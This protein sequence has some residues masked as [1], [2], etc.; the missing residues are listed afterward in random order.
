MPLAIALPKNPYNNQ[1]VLLVPEKYL[2]DLP[3]IS[4]DTF[5][6]FCYTNENET[7]RN[8][9][10]ADITRNVDKKTIINFARKHPE[11]RAEFLKHVEE[12][13]AKPYDYSADRRGLVKWYDATAQ[14]CSSVPLK[15]QFTSVKEFVTSIQRLLAEFRNYV[16]NNAGWRLLWN[17]NGQ[18]KSEEA[19]QL[20][21]LGVVKHYCKANDIDISREVNIGRGPVDFK[22]SQ[23]YQF[24]S[25]LELKLARNTK[26]WNGLARQLPKYQEAE[27]VRIGYFIIVIQSEEDLGRLN[28]LYAP[29]LPPV[30]SRNLLLYQ[31]LPTSIPYRHANVRRRKDD[32]RR[33][34]SG[35]RNC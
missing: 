11:L 3:T 5:W 1:P 21:F 27:D 14:Y 9:F 8:D 25:L 35:K 32:T 7:L 10:S 6:D 24:R 16:E 20:L 4:S 34:H 29:L 13:G 30:A 18:P 26:F 22:V 2:R 12:E 33:G 28:L 17:D 23:G 31:S 19:A 15:L